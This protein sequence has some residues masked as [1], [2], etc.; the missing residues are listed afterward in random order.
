MI[1]PPITIDSKLLSERKR[2]QS[3]TV[4]VQEFL[5]LAWCEQKGWSVQR[6]EHDMSKFEAKIS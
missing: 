6:V 3:M 2:S 5:I 4:L 1:H